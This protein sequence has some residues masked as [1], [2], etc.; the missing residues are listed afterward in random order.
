MSVSK[1]TYDQWR[2]LQ[3]SIATEAGIVAPGLRDIILDI[4]HDNG[5]TMKLEE[6]R[7]QISQRE[8]ILNDMNLR[9]AVSNC[10]RDLYDKKIV[11]KVKRGYYTLQEVTYEKF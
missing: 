1:I 5:G 3:V 10:I 8:L 11:H 7:D 4:L 6:I 2:A 9:A